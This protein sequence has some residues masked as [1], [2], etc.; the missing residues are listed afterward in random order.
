[1]IVY[2]HVDHEDKSNT[3]LKN[4]NNEIALPMM[5]FPHNIEAL[6]NPIFSIGDTGTSSHSSNYQNVIMTL[7]DRQDSDSIMVGSGAVVKVNKIGNIIGE[8][9]DNSGTVLQKE[10]MVNVAH[11]PE[12][13]CNMYSLTMKL[14][15]GWQLHGYKDAIWIT[16]GKA[17]LCFNIN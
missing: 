17:K 10:Q 11:C 7:N 5:H 16:R 8:V 15:E 12:M 2:V 1:M 3:Y 6:K 4:N 14:L 13:R 9:Y